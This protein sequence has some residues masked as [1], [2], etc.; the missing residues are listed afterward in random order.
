MGRTL[1]CRF[2]AYAQLGDVSSFVK[3]RACSERKVL[4]AVACRKMRTNDISWVGY[5]DSRTS[6]QVRDR[7]FV[8]LVPLDAKVFSRIASCNLW[9]WNAIPKIV[10]PAVTLYER[11]V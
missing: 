8:V 9:D 1:S 5:D 3:R 11:G 4:L 10:E 2:L 6:V 7:P